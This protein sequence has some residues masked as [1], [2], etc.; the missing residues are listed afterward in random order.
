MRILI[1]HNT[2]NDSRSVSGVLRHYAWMANEWIAAGH[3]TDFIV[4]RAGFPQ[5]QSLAPKSRLISSDDWFD[6]TRYIAQTWRYFPAYAWRMATAHWLRLPDQYDLVYSSTQLIVEVYAAMIL[7]SRARAK[8]VAKIHHVLAAQKRRGGFFDRLFLWSERKTMRWMNQHADLLICGTPLVA[9]DFHALERTLGLPRRETIQ[10]GYGVDLEAMPLA[11]NRRKRFDV[12]VLGRLHEHKGVF[13]LPHVWREVLQHRPHS[14]LLVIGEGPHRPRVE[15]IFQQM[16][17][18]QSVT[19]T[20]G[21]EETEKNKMLCESRIG[22]SLSF[23]EGWGLSIN[24]FLAARLPVVAYDLPIYAHVFPEQIDLVPPGDRIGIAKKLLALL[25]NEQ[26]QEAQGL[27]G[28]E[29]VRR[30]DFRNVASQELAALK[31]L[32]SQPAPP[33]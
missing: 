15:S 28:R 16:G 33:E 27:R 25:D 13:D 21:I 2:L 3:P 12:V 4:A 10:I 31:E 19:F 5:L 22:L 1:V 20:G 23:E 29:F 26:R 11:A 9:E 17:I 6:A 30:Y 7:A 32:I 14:H 8:F 18:D 24:E